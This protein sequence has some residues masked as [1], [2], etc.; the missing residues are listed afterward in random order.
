MGTYPSNLSREPVS[1]TLPVWHA[2][3]IHPASKQK[4]V[5]TLI[6][7]SIVFIQAIGKLVNITR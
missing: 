3:R 5:S 2:S 6:V 7:P 1:T 4:P